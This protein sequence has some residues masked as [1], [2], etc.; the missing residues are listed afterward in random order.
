MKKILIGGIILVVLYLTGVTIYKSVLTKESQ[1]SQEDQQLNPTPINEVTYSCDNGKDILASFF[2][3]EPA[4]EISAGQPPSPS[5]SVT[6]ILS[7]GRKLALKQTISGSGTRYA[8]NDES[9][10]F[11]GEGDT[12][13]LTENNA[14]TY[15][16]CTSSASPTGETTVLKNKE[17]DRAVTDFLLS[18]KDFTWQTE[19][20]SKNFCVFQNLDQENETFPLYI[21]ARCGEFKRVNGE[22]T[23]LSG[24]SV[25][26]KINYPNKL[27]AYDLTK[28]TYEIPGSGSAYDDDIKKIFPQDLWPKLNFDG[29]PLN[30]KILQVA[31]Q[32]LP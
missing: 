32:S 2:K 31:E 21:W 20:D 12:A 26:V 25:P 14:Q 5:G 7:D 29:R 6:L 4:K 3:G 16:G 18:Q 9:I 19:P 11:W 10:V 13:F 1:S 27:T 22:L 28:F 17:L 30:A 23:E 8:N 15:S 24:A